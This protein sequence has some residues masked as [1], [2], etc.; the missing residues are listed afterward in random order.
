MG[1]SRASVCL[2]PEKKCFALSEIR[3]K[4]EW[5]NSPLVGEEVQSKLH[6]EDSES[7]LNISVLKKFFWEEFEE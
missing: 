1:I 7:F 2:L 3:I 5:E 4:G 6:A